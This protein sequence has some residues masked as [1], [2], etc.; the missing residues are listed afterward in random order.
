VRWRAFAILCLVLAATFRFAWIGDVEYKGDERGLFDQSQAIR[1]TQLWPALGFPGGQA[2]HPALGP[3]TFA[4]L[5]HAFDLDSPLSLTR[6]VQALSFAAVALLFVFAWRLPAG[7]QREIWLWTAAFASVNLFAVI[8]GRKIWH[9]DLM[10]IY[11][12]AFLFAW[13]HRR[14]IAGALG[15]GLT[16]ALIGQ[17]HMSGFF[18]ASAWLLGTI[19]FA[20]HTVRWRA[21]L[22]GS[23]CGVLPLLPWLHYMLTPGPRLTGP[24]RSDALFQFDYFRVAFANAIGDSA[25]HS[26]GSDFSQYLH[27]PVLWGAETHAVW[28]ARIVLAALGIG[29]ALV[30]LCGV[31]VHAV[32]GRA[33]GWA[34]DSTALALFNTLLMALLMS[35]SRLLVFPHYHAVAYPFE[36]LWLA[37]ALVTFAPAPRLW[38]ATVWIGLALCTVSYL[39]YVHD[40][41]GAPRGDYGV[42]Y[43]CQDLAGERPEPYPDQPII[44]SGREAMVAEMLGTGEAVA[45]RCQFTDGQIEPTM[46]RA[47]YRCGADDVVVALRHPSKTTA[48]AIR[49]DRFAI[50]VVSGSPPGALLPSLAARIR[51]REAR[52]EW[53]WPGIPMLPLRTVLLGLLGTGLLLVVSAPWWAAGHVRGVSR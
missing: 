7:R 40:H 50:S 13:W 39:Q 38:L 1:R 20:R 17:V 31:T 32:K 49:T 41:C 47:V 23:V 33:R 29:A 11:S 19:A 10:P 16:G 35:V 25:E 5:V 12:V 8:H 36:F 51:A 45:D 2:R 37:A 44:P 53:R 43:R 34:D 6:A 18:S 46:I 28:V 15:W 48:D 42:A 22:A 14:R 52:F 21:W 26:L 4:L 27:Y 3:W 30:G 24:A 9:P